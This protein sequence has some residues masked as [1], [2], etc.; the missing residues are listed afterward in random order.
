VK[1]AEFEYHAP[2]T[3]E[4]VLALL[5]EF[6]ENAKVLAGGQSLVQRM[7]M[8][9]V[10]PSHVIDVNGV[11]DLSKLTVKDGR[12]CL[13]SMVRQATLE[14]SPLVAEACPLLAEAVPLIASPQ[15]RNRGTVGG[16]LAYASPT[17]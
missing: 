15:V 8:R 1:P 13:G 14:R 10:R 5:A 11:E 3:V 6:G 12:I 4:E 7:N 2:R 9:L 17:A 16:S